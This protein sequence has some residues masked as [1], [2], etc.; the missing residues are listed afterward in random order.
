MKGIRLTHLFV[1]RR[2]QQMVAFLRR[3]EAKEQAK[4]EALLSGALVSPVFPFTILSNGRSFINL[5]KPL[6]R[7][8]YPI[9]TG[10]LANKGSIY[11]DLSCW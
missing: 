1:N 2:D 4:K 9:S 5:G 3:K 11:V 10:F 6:Q 7:Q 8:I